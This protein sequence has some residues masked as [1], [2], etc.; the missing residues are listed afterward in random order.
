V[1]ELIELMRTYNLCQTFGVLPGPGGLLDQDCV[2]V[3]VFTL[4]TSAIAEKQEM[5]T[6]QAK[7]RR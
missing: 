2:L 6:Q 7:S 4:I 5:E 3:Q 1:F